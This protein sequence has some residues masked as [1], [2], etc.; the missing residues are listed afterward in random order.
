MASAATTNGLRMENWV[1]FMPVVSAAAPR[2]WRRRGGGRWTGSND[3]LAVRQG[4]GPRKDDRIAGLDSACDL[5]GRRVA[6]SDVDNLHP[7][8][9]VNRREDEL[10]SRALLQ[11]CW[12]NYDGILRVSGL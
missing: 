8:P 6:E 10:F 2:D 12:R 5:D 9:S 1:R 3:R 11:R 7:G 4:D